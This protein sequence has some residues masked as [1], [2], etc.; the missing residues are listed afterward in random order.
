MSIRWMFTTQRRS[1]ALRAFAF[2][3]ILVVT[4]DRFVLAEEHE[5]NRCLPRH[6]GQFSDW[7]EPVN[8][9]P[10][11]NSHFNDQHP[12]ISRDRLSLYISSDR[13]GGFGDFDIYVSHRASVNVSG[14]HRRTSAQSSTRSLRTVC[15]RFRR[16]GI[17]CI[18]KV[19]FQEASA[20]TTFGFRFAKTQP[21]ISL[22]RP[23]R[24]LG[25]ESTPT[26][27]KAGQ[28]SSRIDT[29]G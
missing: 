15:L 26:N 11:V 20:T 2:M 13:P 18:S 25:A 10:V 19:A 12:A 28:P 23:Q 29:T 16:T 1:I 14:A 22:G 27:Q 5:H 3:L 6:F 8:L 21:T 17:E 7:S 4:P 24:I 9:G